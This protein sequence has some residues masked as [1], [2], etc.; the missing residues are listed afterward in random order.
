MLTIKT[1]SSSYKTLQDAFSKPITKS[2][3]SIIERAKIYNRLWPMILHRKAGDRINNF[4]DENNSR[5]MKDDIVIVNFKTKTKVQ[6]QD[7]SQ[8]KMNKLL[9]KEK[10]SK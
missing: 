6:S 7:S 9:L 10:Y 2:D 1:K 5:H 3:Q 4:S 8:K